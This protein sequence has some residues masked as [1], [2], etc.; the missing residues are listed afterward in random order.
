[1]PDD[2]RS[3]A[4]DLAAPPGRLN[5]FLFWPFW[6][7]CRLFFRVWFRLRIEGA[8][9][10]DGAYVVAANHASMADPIVLGASIRRRVA[11]MM[12][13]MFWRSPTFGWFFRWNRAIPIALRGGNRE[14]MRA[15]RSVLQ[16]GRIVGIFPEGGLSRDGLM[17]LGN[18]GAVSLVLN[19][20]VPIVPV[21][22]VGASRA[23]A[24]GARWP[25]PRRITVRFGEPI[26]SVDLDTLAAGDRR[27]RLQAATRLIMDRIALLCGQ[28]S[29]EA[30]LERHAAESR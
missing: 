27:G 11:F 16:Q 26:R 4:A 29:R 28:V 7:A 24:P 13:E 20:G 25:R 1:L 15:A 2:A 22:I 10:K 18:P 14:A 3:P 9:P 12:T 21:G 23:L 5:E 8:P 6:L 30:V 17:I 19:E